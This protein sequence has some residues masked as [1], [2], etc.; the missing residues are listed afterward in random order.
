M[1]RPRLP[2][3]Y[4]WLLRRISV[5]VFLLS[6]LSV[7]A[8]EPDDTA[9]AILKAGAARSLLSS[10]PAAPHSL[11][12]SFSVHLSGAKRVDGKYVLSVTPTGDWAKQLFFADYSDLQVAHGAIVWIQRSVAFQPLQ[13]AIVQNAFSSPLHI[14]E[15]G[16]VVDR[17]FKMSDHHVELR[18]VDLLRGRSRRTFCLD[19]D[20]NLTTITLHSTRITYQYSDFRPVGKRFMP[21]RITGTHWGK[22]VLDINL[23]KVAIDSETVSQLPTPAEGSIKRA[24]CLSPTLPTLKHSEFPSFPMSGPHMNSL[25]R[26]MLYAL[27]GS[28]GSV[29][30][31]SVTQTGGQA[32]DSSALEAVR[33]WQYEPAKCGDIPVDFETELSLNFSMEIQE[34]LR[35]WPR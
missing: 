16:D 1:L 6:S 33:R 21:Y 9:R 18:C 7:F 14:D 11:A 25:R 23:D 34:E 29:K 17:Y 32:F 13:A 20:Q 28:D 26:V 10:D 35:G 22:S 15:S 3:R 30:N 31:A 4:F 24:G 19:P 8:K 2:R 12:A 5:L 27:I